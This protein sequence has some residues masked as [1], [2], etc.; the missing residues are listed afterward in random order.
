[1]ERKKAQSQP[2]KKTVKTCGNEPF[3][4]RSKVS[5]LEKTL[6]NQEKVIK[7]MYKHLNQKDDKE[8]IVRI[9][10]HIPFI[11]NN[12]QKLIN[13]IKHINY[14]MTKLTKSYALIRWRC[15]IF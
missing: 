2:K 4:L 12:N 10:N 14:Y 5:N 8:N 6:K 13:K 11:W 7:G 9:N 3:D 15:F 1:M